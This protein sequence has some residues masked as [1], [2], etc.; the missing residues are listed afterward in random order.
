VRLTG[1]ALSPPPVDLSSDGKHILGYRQ[2]HDPAFTRLLERK[3]RFCRKLS[4][5]DMSKFKDSSYNGRV[6]YL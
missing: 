5:S 1:P 2:T 6:V 3:A 4:K